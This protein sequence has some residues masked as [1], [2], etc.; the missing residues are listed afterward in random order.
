MGRTVPTP[1]AILG[2]IAGYR[3]GSVISLTPQ[4]RALIRYRKR[5]ERRG[6]ARFEVLGL[7]PIAS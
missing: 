6:I 4:K 3:E 2:Y 7:A 1:I 5:L